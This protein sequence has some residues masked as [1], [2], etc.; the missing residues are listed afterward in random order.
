MLNKFV[1]LWPQESRGL[2]FD[3]FVTELQQTHNKR[4]LWLRQFRN[5]WL[6]KYTRLPARLPLDDADIARKVV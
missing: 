1:A 3:L 4:A 5:R 2:R 6:S